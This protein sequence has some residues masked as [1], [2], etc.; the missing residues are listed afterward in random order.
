[1]LRCDKE[2]LKGLLAP[3][4]FIIGW[5]LIIGAG[6]VV[7][8]HSQNAYAATPRQEYKTY[9]GAKIKTFL[10][11]NPHISFKINNGET[12]DKYSS[13]DS[14]GRM[15]ANNEIITFYIGII[16][17]ELLI[18]YNFQKIPN[19]NL[20]VLSRT[21]F[22]DDAELLVIRETIQIKEEVPIL[23][24]EA[25]KEKAIKPVIVMLEKKEK[26]MGLTL[27]TWIMLMIMMVVVAKIAHKLRLRTIFRPTKRAARHVEKEW[28]ES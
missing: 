21:A 5:C 22:L 14:L 20:E 23:A 1:M 13:E 7:K 3:L 4:Y 8:N 27:G 6:Y 19:T 15:K 26:A 10:F 17:Q 24:I 9:K 11:K 2:I 28:K 12:Y 18:S 16:E 25:P